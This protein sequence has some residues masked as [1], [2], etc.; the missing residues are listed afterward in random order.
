MYLLMGLLDCTVKIGLFVHWTL[1]RTRSVVLFSHGDFSFLSNTPIH[2]TLNTFYLCELHCIGQVY[3]N[4]LA[5]HTSNTRYKTKHLPLF[6]P[7]R[8]K[9]VFS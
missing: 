7:P 4:V 3:W 8:K 6:N 1:M 5:Y 2:V 9:M